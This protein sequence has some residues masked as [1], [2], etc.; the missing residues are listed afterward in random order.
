MSSVKNINISDTKSRIFNSVSELKMLLGLDKYKFS[1]SELKIHNCSITDSYTIYDMSISTEP[2]IDMPFFLMTPLE[3]EIIDRPNSGR[4]LSTYPVIL[5]PHGHGSDGR[6]GVAGIYRHKGMEIQQKKYNHDIGV[7]FV[8]RGYIVLCPDSR[9]A[10]DRR[11]PT[12]QGVEL[13]K[14]LS[15]SCLDLNNAF[16]SLGSSLIGA[17]CW[18]FQRLID[19]IINNKWGDSNNIGVCGF[20]GGGLQSLFLSAL[21]RRIKCTGISG[22]FFRYEDCFLDSNLCSCNFIPSFF[23]SYS[24]ASLGVLISPRALIIEKGISD[25]LNGRKGISGPRMLTEVVKSQYQDLNYDNRYFYS[26]FEGSHKFNGKDVFSFF[27]RFLNTCK[28][29]PGVK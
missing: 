6:Y 11:N 27:D 5:V 2:E 14:L 8:K 15:S 21:D 17:C 22:Y 18:D 25:P 7:Q 4:Q 1:D 24:M 19:L 29:S 3:A 12:E 26:E 20:S 10:G 28:Y 9:G 13:D 16:I 23:E